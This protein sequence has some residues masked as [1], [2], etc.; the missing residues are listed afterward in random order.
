[1]EPVGSLPHSQVPATCPYTEPA[2]SGVS[3]QVRGFLCELFLAW[4][5]FTMRNCHHLA[6]P[7][8]WRTTPCRLSS[9]PYS[10]YSQLPSIYDAVPPSATWGRALPWWQG[11]TF[12]GVGLMCL[13]I[14]YP[15]Q[16]S[17]TEIWNSSSRTFTR[18]VMRHN[19]TCNI[20]LILCCTFGLCC[21]V[22]VCI[23]YG[24]DN[25]TGSQLGISNI[26]RKWELNQDKG[27]TLHKSRA[28]LIQ[29]FALHI[30]FIIL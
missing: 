19:C 12:K 6:Q 24:L 11:P 25:I 9:T 8:S 20:P 5:L 18:T 22:S 2:W 7:P 28:W 15:F 3:V 29:D 26:K 17:T 30:Y 27:W 23:E 14:V 10:I 21:L 1:M 16:S 4:S 13:S